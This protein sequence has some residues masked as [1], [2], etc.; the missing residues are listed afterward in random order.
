MLDAEILLWVRLAKGD[1]P[2]HP[3]RGN[4]YTVIGSVSDTTNQKADGLARQVAGTVI[5]TKNSHMA[6][7]RRHEQLAGIHRALQMQ[8]NEAAKTG[9]TKK[10]RAELRQA[11]DLH[12]AASVAH[13]KAASAHALIALPQPTLPVTAEAATKLSQEAAAASD[14]A[15][16]QTDDGL[17]QAAIA[18]KV[19]A[20]VRNPNPKPKEQQLEFRYD[21]PVP[22]R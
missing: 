9:A 16:R 15:D 2:G 7:A 3:F 14:L 22:K 20:P 4:Q 12:K 19:Q 5:P 17:S 10:A 8:L 13:S 21:E 18:E 11:A 6:F 1:A